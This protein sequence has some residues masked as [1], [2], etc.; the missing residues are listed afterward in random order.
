MRAADASILRDTSTDL[1][2]SAMVQSSSS[3]CLCTLCLLERAHVIILQAF[4][5]RFRVDPALALLDG[6]RCGVGEEGSGTGC[7]RTPRIPL[8]Y[9]RF[10][11]ISTCRD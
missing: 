4:E 9:S 6:Q 8:S 1:L 3:L 10:H 2:S 5:R 11:C 7:A